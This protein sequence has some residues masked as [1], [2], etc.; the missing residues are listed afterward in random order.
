MRGIKVAL[1]N[2]LAV[3]ITHFLKSTFSLA[4]TMSVLSGDAEHIPGEAMIIFASYL[5]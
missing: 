2:V 3:G 4:L 5:S 1:K